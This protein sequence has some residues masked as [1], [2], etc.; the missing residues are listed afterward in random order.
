[1]I[2]SVNS[3]TE[4]QISHNLYYSNSSTS[5]SGG[6]Y[7]S[8]EVLE[9]VEPLTTIPQPGDHVELIGFVHESSIR[10][11]DIIEI[12]NSDSG[13]NDPKI[14]YRNA[15]SQLQDSN[16]ID[17]RYTV[18]F[19]DLYEYDKTAYPYDKYVIGDSIKIIDEDITGAGGIDLRVL[20]ESYS[21]ELP[22]D[23]SHTLEV[24]KKPQSFVR[25]DYL[26]MQKEV[27]M[28]SQALE[29]S[30][31]SANIPV[32][33]HW[34]HT[35]KTCTRLTPPNYFCESDESNTDGKMTKEKIRITKLH[36][37]SYRPST[38]L[39]VVGGNTSMIKTLEQSG[40]GITTS[41]YNDTHTYP[42]DV[43]FIL[44]ADSTQAHVLDAFNT[45]DS[46]A[47]FPLSEVDIEI[48]KDPYGNVV[49]YNPI[50]K[51]TGTGG[52]FRLKRDSGS[53]AN[54]T[55]KVLIVAVGYKA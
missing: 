47:S 28:I 27:G 13:V 26:Q 31:L 2:N 45:A 49:P 4:L 3:E 21:P 25:D 33:M 41:D 32:C 19:V 55:V 48:K 37:Q 36:C 17:P 10:K 44:D 42:I 1:M 8:I 16:V 20:K 18:S 22:E 46:S 40:I 14:L 34:N 24:S 51:E 50:G 39:R 11:N 7:Y 35:M 53:A 15:Y 6:H 12:T 29:E 54:P 38:E 30:K 52:Y 9:T 5:I 43:N 23:K